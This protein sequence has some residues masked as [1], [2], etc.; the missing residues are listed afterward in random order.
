MSARPRCPKCGEPA[1]FVLMRARVRCLLEPDGSVMPTAEVVRA[2]ARDS[3]ERTYECGGGHRWTPEVEKPDTSRYHF[4]VEPTGESKPPDET[5]W[6]WLDE[7]M[8]PPSGDPSYARD[9]LLRKTEEELGLYANPEDPSDVSMV[10]RAPD[11]THRRFIWCDQGTGRS[12]G[13]RGDIVIEG[14][15]PQGVQTRP[16]A[17]RCTI[18]QTYCH[19][20]EFAHGAEAEELR[21][22]IEAILDTACHVDDVEDI[23]QALRALLDR[24]DAR[25]SLAYSEARAREEEEEES[26]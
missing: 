4:I 15:R 14:L 8:I 5:F 6:K 1:R 20:H 26:D 21:E 18:Y 2:E 7:C 24:V 25:D 9:L 10:V 23:E 13:R 22:G 16:S 11:G 19:E 17:P 12:V 3:E